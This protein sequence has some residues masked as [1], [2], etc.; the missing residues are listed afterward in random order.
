MSH[1][2]FTGIVRSPSLD[3]PN[4]DAV[5]LWTA[6]GPKLCCVAASRHQVCAYPCLDTPNRDAER[7][8]TALGPKLCRVAATRHQVCAYPCLDTPNRDA[9][10]LWTA[11]GPRL[12]RVAA[13]RTEGHGRV[14]MQNILLLAELGALGVCPCRIYYFWQN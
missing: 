11:L 12:C 7:L 10:R 13:T 3:T 14:P 6:L 8:W 5:R 2:L 4:R 1:F 9:V